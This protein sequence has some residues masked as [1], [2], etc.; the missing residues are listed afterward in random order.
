MDKIFTKQSRQKYLDTAI[1]E[2]SD[3]QRSAAKAVN[4]GIV[5]GITQW[6]LARQLQVYSRT[7]SNKLLKITSLEVY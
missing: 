3:E 5:Y 4:F 1:E 2:V 7:C 6:G